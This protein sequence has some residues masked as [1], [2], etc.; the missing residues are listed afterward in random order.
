MTDIYSNAA[1]VATSIADRAFCSALTCALS[2]EDHCEFKLEESIRVG[3]QKRGDVIAAFLYLLTYVVEIRTRNEFGIEDRVQELLAS[4]RETYASQVANWAPEGKRI[5]SKDGRTK[6]V[7]TRF[8][9]SEFQQARSSYGAMELIVLANVP[10]PS[11]TVVWQFA[12]ELSDRITFVTHIPFIHTAVSGAYAAIKDLDGFLRA[13]FPLFHMWWDA[14]P[15]TGAGLDESK[16][17]SAEPAGARELFSSHMQ[18]GDQKFETDDIAALR[19][20]QEAAAVCEICVKSG[21]SA[22]W[23]R[24][25]AACHARCG[26]ALRRLGRNDEACEAYG[27]SISIFGLLARED[28]TSGSLQG[29]LAI[30]LASMAWLYAASDTDVYAIYM[31]LCHRKLIAM[32]SAGMAMY[33]DLRVLLERL[34]KQYGRA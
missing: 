21:L 5:T 25:L 10:P 14:V 22:G 31:A 29:D 6:L 30:S 34:D 11:G 2:L 19:A 26:N 3:D 7:K 20:Y 28:P 12:S 33:P 4:I 15:D 13:V 18:Y 16:Q 32:R 23:S 17:P 24:D 9:E 1:L 27:R 8:V